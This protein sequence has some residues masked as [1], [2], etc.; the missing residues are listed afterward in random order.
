MQRIT[1]DERLGPDLL[2]LLVAE[3]KDPQQGRDYFDEIEDWGEEA[4]ILV[5]GTSFRE[6]MGLGSENIELRD[7]EEGQV[8]LNGSFVLKGPAEKP[9]SFRVVR[10]SAQK[11]TRIDALSKDKVKSKV[12]HLMSRKS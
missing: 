6:V 3:M 7:L 8:F 4:E 5:D 10:G 11:P 9:K 1:V 12:S 2:R